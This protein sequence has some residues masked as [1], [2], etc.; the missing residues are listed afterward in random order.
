[1]FVNSNA[2]M[3]D[4]LHLNS[5]TVGQLLAQVS[6]QFNI[7][8]PATPSEY[9]NA[10]IED[11]AMYFENA[12]ENSG[13]ESTKQSSEI[14]GLHDWVKVFSV[15]L[16]EDKPI[17]KEIVSTDKSFLIIENDTKRVIYRKLKVEDEINW[18]FENETAHIYDHNDKIIGP[19]GLFKYFNESS[20]GE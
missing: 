6:K 10:S 16:K 14:L 18:Q 17:N 11:I 13:G 19:Y 2:K 5:I 1:M 7:P 20:D 12:N 3:L 9:S 4:D 15:E 8:V